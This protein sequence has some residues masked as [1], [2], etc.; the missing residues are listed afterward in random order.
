MVSLWLLQLMALDSIHP[1]G[2]GWICTL[3]YLRRL[4]KSVSR[5]EQSCCCCNRGPYAVVSKAL[6]FT[7][8]PA[9]AGC[10]LDFNRA[11]AIHR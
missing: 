2:A 10:C 8:H 3:L 1:F 6:S 7:L 9:V 5:K 4:E 11:L